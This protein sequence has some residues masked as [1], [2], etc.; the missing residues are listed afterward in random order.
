MLRHACANDAGSREEEA[1]EEATAEDEVE[2][3]EDGF[4]AAEDTGV[5]FRSDDKL[6]VAMSPLV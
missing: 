5:Y 6:K 3:E 4:E 1:A 2:A